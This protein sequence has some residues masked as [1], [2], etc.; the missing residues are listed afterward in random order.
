MADDLLLRVDRKLAGSG[1][2]AAICDEKDELDFYAEVG[3]VEHAF[4]DPSL[5]RR[6]LDGQRV[7]DFLDDDN[8]PLRL[9]PPDRRATPAHTSAIFWTALEA[10]LRLGMWSWIWTLVGVDHRTHAAVEQPVRPPM[11]SVAA[12]RPIAA[13]RGASQPAVG[14][15]DGSTASVRT[16]SSWL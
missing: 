16:K 12:T 7:C 8:V 9:F 11:T 15:L 4:A 6:R 10:R 13:P 3:L 14:S 5:L 2:V 1:S